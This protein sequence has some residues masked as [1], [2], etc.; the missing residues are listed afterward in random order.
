MANTLEINQWHVAALR[1]PHLSAIV[2]WEGAVDLYRDWAYHGGIPSNVF[3][4][5]RWP[6]QVTG[7]QSA[8]PPGADNPSTAVDDNAEFPADLRAHPYD[9]RYYADRGADLAAITA[10][11]L[12]CGSWSGY[13][14]HLRGNIDGYLDAATGSL[15]PD[16]AADAT[17][18]GYPAPDGAAT[19]LTAS[20]VEDTEI[21]GPIALHV[22]ASTTADRSDPSFV[23]HTDPHDRSAASAGVVSLHTGPHTPSHLLVPVVPARRPASSPA[24]ASA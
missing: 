9:D 10:P 8:L 23:G 12:S 3:T 17:T 13:A 16:R 24:T 19:F 22:W 18:C 7:N 4:D 2:P 1:P 5:A 21:T 14:L 20:L 11:V 15:G 6:R